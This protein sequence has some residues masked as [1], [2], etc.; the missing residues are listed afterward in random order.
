M[1][2]VLSPK[3]EKKLKRISKLDQIALVRKIRSLKEKTA[4]TKS[5]KLSGYHDIF[6]IRV[7]NYR[8][9]YRKSTEEIYIILIG[10]RKDIYHLLKQF[11]S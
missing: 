1:R 8:M 7:G 2:T 5:E 9:V 6:R 10:H 3:A 11:V 4:L